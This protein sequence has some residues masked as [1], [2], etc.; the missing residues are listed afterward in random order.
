MSID[1]YPPRAKRTVDNV[2]VLYPRYYS[3]PGPEGFY[4]ELQYPVQTRL[5][6][7]FH[8]LHN[9]N[10]YIQLN[11]VFMSGL[12]M[13]MTE[14]DVRD[15][16]K[17][18]T[19]EIL[20]TTF[21]KHSTR[22]IKMACMEFS[23]ARDADEVILFAQF[24]NRLFGDERLTVRYSD[25]NSH[26]CS[27]KDI[28]L[29][30][31]EIALSPPYNPR[32]LRQSYLP[33]ARPARKTEELGRWNAVGYSRDS[34][35]SKRPS[36]T[37]C[38]PQPKRQHISHTDNNTRSD[39]YSKVNGKAS[40]KK[41]CDE[42]IAVPIRTCSSIKTSPFQVQKNGHRDG[43]S[44][45]PT[46]AL[47]TADKST[48]PNAFSE[49]IAT[50]PLLGKRVYSPFSLQ[51]QKL[52]ETLEMLKNITSKLKLLDN[53][54]IQLLDPTKH[55]GNPEIDV[56]ADCENRHSN[57]SFNM[58]TGNL[59]RKRPL[60]D[61][62]R[63]E[64]SHHNFSSTP[65]ESNRPQ[66]D[67]GK[68]S[69]RKDNSHDCHREHRYKELRKQDIK[70][71]WHHFTASSADKISAYEP[72]YVG[73]SRDGTQMIFGSHRIDV[74]LAFQSPDQDTAI[75][76][77]QLG[78]KKEAR[79]IVKA[80]EN[81]MK[82]KPPELLLEVDLSSEEEEE[83]IEDE[84]FRPKAKPQGEV[85]TAQYEA[86]SENRLKIEQ[87]E[88]EE[89]EITED[90]ETNM[91]L[92]NHQ[93][94]S[95]QEKATGAEAC[96]TKGEFSPNL[97]LSSSGDTSTENNSKKIGYT[98]YRVDELSK[99]IQKMMGIELRYQFINAKLNNRDKWININVGSEEKKEKSKV[100]V[101]KL[102]SQKSE[103]EIESIIFPIDDV[104]TMENN[105]NH[106]RTII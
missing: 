42:L 6:I 1:I 86:K 10:V 21:K 55:E 29:V 92:E 90:Q 79:K 66:I 34:F 40:H 32:S 45:P 73:V 14:K 19:N 59:K 43:I 93:T 91:N 94:K 53:P 38:A 25:V 56:S 3:D 22:N 89:G 18:I 39:P 46:P 63:S 36:P 17:G 2:L 82:T 60:N 47:N 27:T 12:K 26:N 62:K 37:S 11:C 71:F 16:L 83:E 105:A 49:K 87:V 61:N 78:S 88:Y 41:I 58:N 77:I 8:T 24:N 81:I 64:D 15:I 4:P 76:K 28:L 84:R 52:S 70:G 13:N 5:G 65:Y 50:P 44:R 72:K 51:G 67:R 80:D 48:A 97:S 7:R 23:S 98:I 31:E 103:D 9:K 101:L 99:D 104:E 68:R 33:F 100:K 95:C 85:E 74:E 20:F 54:P 69:K 96:M 35:R 106:G 102:E 30:R 57:D 75:E